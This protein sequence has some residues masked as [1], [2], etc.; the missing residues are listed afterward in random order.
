MW[1]AWY[2][3][4]LNIITSSTL[5]YGVSGLLLML[6]LLTP[7]DIINN[8]SAVVDLLVCWMLRVP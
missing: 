6:L 1:Y 5:D 2:S 4:L 7:N 3:Q 8:M